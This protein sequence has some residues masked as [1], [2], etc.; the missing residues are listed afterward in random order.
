MNKAAYLV[1]GVDT[2]GVR[3]VLCILVQ[4]TIVGG[5]VAQVRSSARI[6]GPP[7]TT[8]VSKPAGASAGHRP[9]QELRK[10]TGLPFTVSGPFSVQCTRRI[11]PSGHMIALTVALGERSRRRRGHVH[12]QITIGFRDGEA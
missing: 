3:H 7:G 10:A 11:L 1:V 5:I 12:T 9:A 6:R 8:H 2:D 4:S